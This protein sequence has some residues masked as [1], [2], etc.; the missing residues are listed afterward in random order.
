MTT[1]GPTDGDFRAD[2]ADGAASLD[3]HFVRRFTEQ[4]P[5]H[6]AASFTDEQLRGVVQAFGLR[7][8][9]R[10]AIDV[11]FTLPI[12]GRTWYFV[13]LG[14]LDRRPRD[15]RGPRPHRDR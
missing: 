1:T 14:G 4:M 15:R 3:H 6:I 11:R 8:W 13:I 9:V 5:P 12:L 2:A 7:R 10:H